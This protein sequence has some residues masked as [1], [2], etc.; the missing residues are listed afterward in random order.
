MPIKLTNTTVMFPNDPPPQVLFQSVVV[1]FLESTDWFLCIS[2]YLRRILT[3]ILLVQDVPRA[4]A[5]HRNLMLKGDV[6]HALQFSSLHSVQFD[7]IRW[8]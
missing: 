7:K 2:V 6:H 4:L 8:L 3:T 1:N 5:G